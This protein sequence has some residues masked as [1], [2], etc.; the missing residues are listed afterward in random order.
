MDLSFLSAKVDIS[1]FSSLFLFYFKIIF[2]CFISI[3]TFNYELLELPKYTVQ[4]SRTNTIIPLASLR[5]GHFNLT[6][7]LERANI[8]FSGGWSLLR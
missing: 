8:H 3:L 5:L 2:W 4:T 6:A 7:H 1:K